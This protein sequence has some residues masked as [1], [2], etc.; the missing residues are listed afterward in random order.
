MTLEHPQHT[1]THTHTHTHRPNICSEDLVP[2]LLF[3][4]WRRHIH[5]SLK[6]HVYLEAAQNSS[7]PPLYLYFSIYFF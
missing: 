5:I 7:A 4:G 6:T 2:P 1:H 3:R